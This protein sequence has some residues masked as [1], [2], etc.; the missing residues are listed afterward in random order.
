MVGDTEI[1][2]IA[3]K[4]AGTITVA[5]NYGFGDQASLDAQN[6]DFYISEPI[7]LKNLFHRTAQ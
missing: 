4:Q 7:E 1:D 6:P 2:L 5:A 3:G